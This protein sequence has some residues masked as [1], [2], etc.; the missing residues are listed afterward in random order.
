MKMKTNPCL[1][2]DLRVWL[3]A[4]AGGGDVRFT[5]TLSFEVRP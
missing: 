4:T 1:R 5:A 2:R 3:S